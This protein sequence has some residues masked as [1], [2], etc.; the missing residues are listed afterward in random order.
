MNGYVFIF[1]RACLAVWPSVDCVAVAAAVSSVSQSNLFQL[2]AII[3]K[4]VFQSAFWQTNAG[5]RDTL[6][7]ECTA[8]LQFVAPMVSLNP[9]LVL[10]LLSA[11]R[12]RCG[13]GGEEGD[14]GRGRGEAH[15]R[16]RL[17]RCAF[18]LGCSA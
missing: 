5:G 6:A 14:A 17:R 9:R 11:S 16:R 10:R 2:T 13:C 4:Y 18:P 15:A 8:A 1:P 7:R 12:G 3:R